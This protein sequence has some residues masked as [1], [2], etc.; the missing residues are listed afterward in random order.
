MNSRKFFS[1]GFWNMPTRPVVAASIAVEGTLY[2]FPLFATY[3]P[4]HRW[5][6]RYRVVPVWTIAF[7]IFPETKV[8]AE[9]V[10][11]KMKRKE[12]K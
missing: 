9:R 6:S 8:R 1:L 2:G 12:K 5:N 7:M 11:K 3:E 4:L 10:Q